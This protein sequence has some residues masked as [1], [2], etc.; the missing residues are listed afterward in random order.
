M[1][2]PS[3]MCSNWWSRRASLWMPPLVYMAAIYL[4]SSQS[5][6]LPQLTAIVWDKVLHAIEYAGL[7]FLLGRAFTGEGF[8]RVASIALAVLFACAYGASDEWHQLF[9]PGRDSDVF[10][11]A[12][13][14]LGAGVGA[15]VHQIF[16]TAIGRRPAS[17]VEI[18]V[19]SA[20][21]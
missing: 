10:D 9:T 1:G 7:A 8:G 16:A 6:P 21:L 20:E 17:D 5:A 19:R 2:Y 4:L 11:W 14:A 15:A 13:D 3:L 12:A 18:R